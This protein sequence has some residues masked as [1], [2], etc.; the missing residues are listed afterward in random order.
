MVAKRIS[1]AYTAIVTIRPVTD[2]TPYLKYAREQAAHRRADPQIA[3]RR[4][5]AWEVVGEIAGFLRRK[6]TP[7]RI[8]VFG[9]LVHPDLF[10]MGSDIDIAVEGILW[11]D[12]LRAWNAVEEHWP[13]FKID[14]IDTGIVSERMRQRIAE[15][16]QEI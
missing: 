5:R 4:K 2:Y 10:G 13:E 15:H 6:Y 9:S 16:G 11:P 8:V 3:A 12:Y 1:Q 7:T 14:L